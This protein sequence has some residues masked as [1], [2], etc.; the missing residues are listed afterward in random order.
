MRGEGRLGVFCTLSTCRISLQDF[1]FFS[2]LHIYPHPSFL[3]FFLFFPLLLSFFLLFRKS[4]LFFSVA[5]NKGFV[6]GLP[7]AEVLV[8][9]GLSGVGWNGMDEIRKVG[10]G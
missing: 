5:G 9:S 3:L 7:M 2:M 8:L 1:I 10:N 4:R 6:N